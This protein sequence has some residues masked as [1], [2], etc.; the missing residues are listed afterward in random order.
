MFEKPIGPFT[1]G[2]DGM[3]EEAPQQVIHPDRFE[4]AKFPVTNSSEEVK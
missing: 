2:T 3:E 4:I 1:M